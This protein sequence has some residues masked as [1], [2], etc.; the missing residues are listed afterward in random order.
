MSRYRR[1]PRRTITFYNRDGRITGKVDVVE[2]PGRGNK[3]V[4]V[5]RPHGAV[6]G[7]MNDHTG[8]SCAQPWQPICPSPTC[9]GNRV[10]RSMIR[11]EKFGPRKHER[12]THTSRRELHG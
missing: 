10:P 12:H 11:F 1:D 7:L 8:A 3:H 6:C 9:P 2:S 4:N 5:R